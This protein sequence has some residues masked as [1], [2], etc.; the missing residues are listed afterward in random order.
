MDYSLNGL[1]GSLAQMHRWKTIGQ[2]QDQNSNS[3]V[4][5]TWAPQGKRRRERPKTT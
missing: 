5:M 2:R 3:N 4:A 1:C